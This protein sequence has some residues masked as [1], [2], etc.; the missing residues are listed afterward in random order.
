[1]ECGS[2]LPLSARKLASGLGLPASWRA[3]S[4]SKLPHSII[5]SPWLRP[6]TSWLQNFDGAL[7]FAVCPVD[8]YMLLGRRK[9]HATF[10]LSRV[11]I[12]A[13]ST[14]IVFAISPSFGRI[15]R[16]KAVEH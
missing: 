3:E 15:K 2:L 5:A 11:F 4:G 9:N 8:H 16:M 12:P 7:A 10:R 6:F 1:M 13:F 14:Y